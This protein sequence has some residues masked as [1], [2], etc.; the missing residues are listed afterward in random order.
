MKILHICSGYPD[1]KLYQNL[2]LELD[3]K[4]VEQLMYVPYNTNNIKNR[5]IL[6]NAN[7]IDYMFSAPYKKLDRLVYYSK[8]HK[9]FRDVRQKTKLNEIDVIH[10]HFL[11]SNGGVAYK[12]KKKFGI[13]YV[14]AVRNTDVNYFFKYGLHVRNY[15]VQI[16]KNA[17]KIVFISPAYKDYVIGKYIPEHLREMISNKSY[18]IP[19]GIDNFWLENIFSDKKIQ[20]DSA[21]IK[22]VSVGELNKNKNVESS[23]K[24]VSL[25]KKKGYKVSLDIVGKGPLEEELKDLIRSTNNQNDIKIH[26]YIE[27]KR[28]LLQIYRESNVFL[29]PSLLETFGLVYIEAMTQGLPVI[30]SRGQGIDGYFSEGQVGKSVF[31]L[32]VKD[33][34]DN[35]EII[36]SSQHDMYE[37]TIQEVN[38]FS[39]SKIADK[40]LALYK[41]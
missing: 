40:Y 33:I 5:R 7:H 22:L 2:L 34:A 3:N 29:M 10:A 31:P 35:I 17:K 41:L 1:T 32:N 20:N 30:Y 12:I 37:R 25:L 23:I 36:M 19:N 4:N 8:I 9:I 27:D 13:D 26:G 15:G 11:F 14:V 16:L 21:N 6:D 38:N 18:V 39:W 28:K 24:T